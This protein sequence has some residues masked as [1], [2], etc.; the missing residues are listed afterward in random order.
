ML[1]KFSAVGRERR[2][3]SNFPREDRECFSSVRCSDL[4]G[5]IS[6]SSKEES[7]SSIEF[8]VFRALCKSLITLSY[9]AFCFLKSLSADAPRC[10]CKAYRLYLL[11]KSAS[12]RSFSPSIFLYASIKNGFVSGLAFFL[13][14]RFSLLSYWFFKRSLESRFLTCHSSSAT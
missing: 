2:S 1:R 6:Y 12:E 4:R 14:L 8:L 9:C 3:Y 5:P 13:P 7:D 10:S 11:R